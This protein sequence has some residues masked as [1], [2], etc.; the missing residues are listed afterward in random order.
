MRIAWKTQLS[1]KQ[2]ESPNSI[3]RIIHL[4]IEKQEGMAR[5]FVQLLKRYL[6]AKYRKK[7]FEEDL[8]EI[9]KKF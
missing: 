5:I 9:S 4:E 2:E 8:K 6:E 7:I 3:V 1:L